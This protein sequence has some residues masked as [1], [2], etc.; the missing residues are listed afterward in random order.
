M[1]HPLGCTGAK[2]SVQ[3]FD[4]MQKR[5][6]K[7]KYA[8]VTMCVGTGQ[9]ARHG[10][11]IRGGEVLEK[12][13]EIDTIVFDKTGTITRGEPAVTDVVASDTWTDDEAE[14]L[15]LAASAERGSE[16]PLGEA[17]VAEA[18]NRELRLSDPHG[19]Q[20]EVGHG[21]Q[22]EVESTSPSLSTRAIKTTKGPASCSPIAF[23]IP[24]RFAPRMAWLVR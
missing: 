11:L 7:D 24:E 21:V 12:M 23:S 18:G 16:H 4:E 8:M 15:R 19:F 17:I 6:L 13:H 20:A 14:L 3:I 9:G 2:L 10:V 1:G 22:A 5:S